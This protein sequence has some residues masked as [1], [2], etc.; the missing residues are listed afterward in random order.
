MKKLRYDEQ[1]I[2]AQT[3]LFHDTTILLSL[4]FIEILFARKS[5]A[6]TILNLQILKWYR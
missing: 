1:I 6:I 5:F 2:C 4:L 3:S